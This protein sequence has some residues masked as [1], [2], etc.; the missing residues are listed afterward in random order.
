MQAKILTQRDGLGVGWLP[1]QRVASMLK[2]GELVERPAA[3]PG[4][5]TVSSGGMVAGGARCN[6]G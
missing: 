2:N 1:R 5:P 3:D 4:E 6:G